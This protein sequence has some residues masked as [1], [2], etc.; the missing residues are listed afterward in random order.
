MRVTIRQ[1]KRIPIP[2]LK[3]DGIYCD[4]ASDNDIL[5]VFTPPSFEAVHVGDVV[6]L[7]PRIFDEP[8]VALNVTT[9]ERFTTELRKQDTH[10]L[11]L[12][13]SHGKSRFPAPERFD[14]G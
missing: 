6:E 1:L 13:A 7:D 10:D 8:Q 14:A 12:P 9:G 2:S 4:G 5:F 3:T 11:R